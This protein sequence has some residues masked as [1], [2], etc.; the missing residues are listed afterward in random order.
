MSAGTGSHVRP[1]GRA[2]RA[3]FAGSSRTHRQRQNRRR[4]IIKHHHQSLVVEAETSSLSHAAL[5]GKQARLGHPTS[6]LCCLSELSQARHGLARSWTAQHTNPKSRVAAPS[7]SCSCCGWRGWT[8]RCGCRTPSWWQVAFSRVLAGAADANAHMN[9]LA[10]R[11]Y[12]VSLQALRSRLAPSREAPP[13]ASRAKL[14]SCRDPN[15]RIL[16]CLTL[17]PDTPVAL[18]TQSH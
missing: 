10:S 6:A 11:S 17:F 2:E 3:V 1:A 14:G 13:L 8:S 15:T 9:V 7:S 12:S 18:V 4:A 16:G 5:A